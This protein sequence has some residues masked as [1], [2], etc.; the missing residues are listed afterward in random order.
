[1]RRGGAVLEV[2]PAG[3]CQG[4]V[5]L[6]G[7]FLVGFGE[8]RHLVWGQAKITQYLPELSAAVD[9]IEELLPHLGRESLSRLALE[10]WPCCVVLRFAASVAVAAF[11]PAGQRAVGH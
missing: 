6:L 10:A 9:R 3:G 8:P 11:Q 1:M 4:G 7:P 2:V 5:Q